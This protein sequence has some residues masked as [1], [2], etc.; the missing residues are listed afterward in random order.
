MT[1]QQL[2][3]MITIAAKGK[4][5]E[6]AKELYITQ[7]SLTSSVRE[8][9]KELNI[10]LFHRTG[11]GITVTR[12]GEEFLAYARQVVEQVD[13]NTPVSVS[14]S[15]IFVFLHNITRSPLK[16]SLICFVISTVMST[17]FVSVKRRPTKLLKMLQS[18]AVRWECCISI[19]IM[20]LCSGRSFVPI[21]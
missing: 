21:I 16:R 11:K 12:E 20:N 17:I 18:C 3:Y 5:S 10:T 14:K 1:L 15:W 9:E 13:R 19:R 2:K 8:L 4:I 7:P 6:A